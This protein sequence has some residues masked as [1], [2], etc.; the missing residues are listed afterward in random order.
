LPPGGGGKMFRA[1]DKAT[2]RVVWETELG[3]GN[4]AP[5]ITYMARGK[6]YIV[7]A[8]AWKG[9]PA[10]LVALALP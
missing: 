7:A 2:G 4:S 8:V 5:P 9:Y 1:Y 3:G 6:Q 10:E